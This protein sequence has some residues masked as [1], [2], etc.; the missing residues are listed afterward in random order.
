MR[1][2]RGGSTKDRTSTAPVE[3]ARPRVESSLTESPPTRIDV[4]P[5][6]RRFVEPR[7]SAQE[8]SRQGSVVRLAIQSLSAPGAATAF[9]NSHHVD[10]GGRPLDIAIASDDG[11]R[12]VEATLAQAAAR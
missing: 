12:A 2:S 3:P 10:L 9:L 11:L 4:R 1:L 5:F 7:L 8:V 6:R